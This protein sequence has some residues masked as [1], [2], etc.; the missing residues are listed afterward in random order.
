M[1]AGY[2]FIFGDVRTGKQYRT[3]DL[4]NTSW[5][6]P[7]G[8]PGSVEGAFPLGSDEWPTAHSDATVAKSYLVVAYVN[9]AGDE[10]LL[11]G[12][13]VWKLDFDHVTEVLRVGA[14]G[15]GSI[16]DHRKVMKVLGA[17]EDPAGASVT[18]TGKQLG[19]IAK[20]LIELTI[21]HAGGNL[22]I[23]LPSDAELGGAGTHIEEVYAGYELAWVGDKLKGLSE[24]DG[25][26]EVQFVPRRRSDDPRYIEWV[27]RIGT[28]DT[29]MLLTQ[30]GQPWAWDTSV[31]KSDV[32]GISI[33]ADGTKMALRQ[34]ASGQG[35]A[36]GTPIA[37]D[38][39]SELLAA[40]FPLLEGQVT[41]VDAEGDPVVLN[42]YVSA[43]LA[44]SQRPIESWTATV[45]RDGR[46]MVGQ[47]RPGD[48][49]RFIVRNHRF[50]PD[51]DYDM[52]IMAISGGD[53]DTVN[54]T[55]SERLGEF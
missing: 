2:R 27:M 4:T 20:R 5:S 11:E 38:T 16:F 21:S 25:G 24:R 8:E 28:A 35:E 30:S 52:R 45:S 42:Q 9:A 31:P 40:G 17:G 44:Y 6:A 48:W 34:W 18:Y 19:L 7:L 54:L 14:A 36:E 22:P 49:A 13:P 29:K 3:V 15:I 47:L 41:A 46:P 50:K 55:L 39:A 33:S 10:T 43:A 51:G 1:A 12:G 23:V 37:V 26:P 53:S 32:R